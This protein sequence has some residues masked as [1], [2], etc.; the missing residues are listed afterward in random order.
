MIKDI[1]KYLYI[2][3]LTLTD[4]ADKL[5][6]DTDRLKELVDNMVHMGYLEMQCDDNV[7]ASA[8]HNCSSSSSC[9]KRNDI[10]VGKTYS[11]TEKGQRVCNKLGSN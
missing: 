1:L 3:N 10:S 6:I 5:G 2:E 4:T 8:C 9:H 11:L 7:E